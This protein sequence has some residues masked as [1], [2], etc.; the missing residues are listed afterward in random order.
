[1]PDELVEPGH[2][3]HPHRVLL[4][5]PRLRPTAPTSVTRWAARAPPH[6]ITCVVIGYLQTIGPSTVIELQI[7]K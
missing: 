2:L 3:A 6:G 5:H 7:E 4:Y 1:M